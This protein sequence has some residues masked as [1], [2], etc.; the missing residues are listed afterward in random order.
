MPP[1][2]RISSMQF[3]TLISLIHSLGLRDPGFSQVFPRYHRLET[4]AQAQVGQLTC[5]FFPLWI[6]ESVAQPFSCNPKGAAM[7]S[8]D[9]SVCWI[10]EL[11]IGGDLSNRSNCAPKIMIYNSYNQSSGFWSTKIMKMFSFMHTHVSSQELLVGSGLGL[12]RFAKRTLCWIVRKEC[13]GTRG[14]ARHFF[15]VSMILAQLTA[16]VGGNHLQTTGLQDND[17]EMMLSG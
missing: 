13:C 4:S 17:P 16:M 2:S 11:G 12:S 10:G 3:L 15:G 1:I 5:F 6:G 9:K 7:H 8:H 14:R